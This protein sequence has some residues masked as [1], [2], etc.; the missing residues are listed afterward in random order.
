MRRGAR[1]RVPGGPTSIVLDAVVVSTIESTPHQGAR[2]RISGP[3]PVTG[4]TLTNGDSRDSSGPQ[5]SS[6]AVSAASSLAER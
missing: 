5:E 2:P 6:A 4:V 3:V 1:V